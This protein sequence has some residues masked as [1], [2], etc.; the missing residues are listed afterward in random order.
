MSSFLPLEEE[1]ELL[2]ELIVILSPFDEATQF[3]SGSKYPTLGFMTPMLEELARRLKY[4]TGHN[5]EAIFVRDTILDNLIERW[6]DPS[7]IGMCCSFLD[8]RFKQLN[9]CTRDLYH[10][11]IQIMRRQFDKLNST[12]TTNDDT[13]PANNNNTISNQSKKSKMSAFFSHLRTENTN[14]MP[15]E[16]DRY[17]ELPEIS[18]DEEPCPLV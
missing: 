16:F 7:E 5:E 3:L 8:P 14:T 13:T 18:L 6:G 15:D 9:F 2:E 17:C 10:S 11:T 12:Q 1:F 4:F